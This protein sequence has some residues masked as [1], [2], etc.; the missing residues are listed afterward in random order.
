MLGALSQSVQHYDWATS[1]Q[2]TNREEAQ[3]THQQTSGLKIYWAR[4][5]PPEQDPV[6]PTA[7]PAHQ[8]ARFIISQP[9]EWIS[10]TQKANHNNH[11]GL[12]SNLSK[13]WVTSCRATEDGWVMATWQN[14][15]MGHGSMCHGS[16][17][18]DKMWPPG[19]GNGNPLQ[20]SCLV[21]SMN[22]IKRQKDMTP[23]DEPPRS[24]GVQRLLGKSRETVPERM[25]R[26][27]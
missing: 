2:T 14:V 12:S 6:F 4:L 15:A 27:T 17:P 19:E 7:S 25:K 3:P 20:Y 9:R 13:L 16:W 1:G 10:Q 21:N 23:E 24:V 8:K 18:H 11:M 26:L 5:C 22:T